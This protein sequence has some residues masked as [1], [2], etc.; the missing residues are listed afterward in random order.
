[1]GTAVPF[2]KGQGREQGERDRTCSCEHSCDLHGQ[3]RTQEY[4][5]DGVSFRIF[6]GEKISV[7][8]W[9]LARRMPYRRPYKV[10]SP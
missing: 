9:L 5:E 10:L 3:L 1:M 4:F 7:S 8:T 2:P 6:V